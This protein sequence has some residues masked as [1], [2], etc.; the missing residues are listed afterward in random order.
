ML[1]T[2]NGYKYMYICIL[3]IL[4][5]KI[6]NSRQLGYKK[7]NYML[8]IRTHFKQQDTDGLKVKV[9]KKQ[10]RQT[11]IKESW[12]SSFNI[13]IK[14]HKRGIFAEIKDYNLQ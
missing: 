6:R 12:N 9:F 14:H 4:Q 11:Q 7:I 3:Y 5:L 8:H 10:T 2:N 1:M 13:K